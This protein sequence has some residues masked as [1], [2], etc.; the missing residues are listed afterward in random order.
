VSAE[1]LWLLLWERKW[2]LSCRWHTC[3]TSASYLSLDTEFFRDKV[4]LPFEYKSSHYWLPRHLKQTCFIKRSF[5]VG[6]TIHTMYIKKL[7]TIRKVKFL[8]FIRYFDGQNRIAM[9]P[10]T[11]YLSQ[12]ASGDV[13]FFLS[14]SIYYTKKKKRV[15]M[16]LLMWQVTQGYDDW[17]GFDY[18]A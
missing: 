10:P 6:S 14:L 12:I 8:A 16:I 9:F 4:E 18:K 7:C 11:L 15:V 3:S 13:R 17:R 2:T 1:T 5:Y